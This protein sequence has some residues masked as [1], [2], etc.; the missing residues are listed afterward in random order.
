MNGNRK[1]YL[2]EL[3]AKEL[4]KVPFDNLKEKMNK[5]TIPKIVRSIKRN[6]HLVAE[7]RVSPTSTSKRKSE[8]D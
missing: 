4:D 7:M 6:E 8:R 3:G 2:E 1:D 5:E